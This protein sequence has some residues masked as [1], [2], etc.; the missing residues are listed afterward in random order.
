MLSRVMVLILC[1]LIALQ[2]HVKLPVVVRAVLAEERAPAGPSGKVTPVYGRTSINVDC[3]CVLAC[4][5]H[6]A[7][8]Q[9]DA[10]ACV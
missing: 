4:T 1:D 7:G 10:R 5:V 9:P 3:A 8:V 6:M 2:A